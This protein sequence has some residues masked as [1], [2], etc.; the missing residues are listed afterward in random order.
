MRWFPYDFP[1]DEQKKDLLFR[2]LREW[3][4]RVAHPDWRLGTAVLVA[5]CGIGTRDP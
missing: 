1:I 4:D 5:N 2:A 3:A